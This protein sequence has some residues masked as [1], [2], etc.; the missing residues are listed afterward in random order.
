VIAILAVLLLAALSKSKEQAMRIAC[1]NS[2][3]QLQ[4]CNHLYALDHAARLPPNNFVYDID[5]DHRPGPC[6]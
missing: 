3:K 6:G 1:L 2:L 5:G 4:I